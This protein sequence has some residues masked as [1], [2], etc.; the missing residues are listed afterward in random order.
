MAMHDLLPLRTARPGRGP[1]N[2]SLAL[3]GGGSLGAFTWGVL[4]RL[5]EQPGIG[6][7][8]ISGASAGVVNAVAGR[9]A[10]R[11]RAR[12]GAQ[13]AGSGWRRISEAGIGVGLLGSLAATAP[14]PPFITPYMINPMDFN[15]LRDIL[16]A[17]VDFERLQRAAPVRLLVAATRVR[18]GS[19]RLFREREITRDAVL[20]SACLPA[21]NHAVEIDGEAYW[22][23]G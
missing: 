8:M 19:L 13:A 23:G 6:F 18:D 21:L 22:D 17:E 16:E 20:A 1:R 11:G 12:D 9:W 4:D 7:N 3:Q 14:P 10:G 2:L 5:L 15:P